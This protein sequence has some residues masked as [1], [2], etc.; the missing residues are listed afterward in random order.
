MYLVS[1]DAFPITAEEIREAIG[2]IG[3]RHDATIEA[4]ISLVC[5]QFGGRLRRETWAINVDRDFRGRVRRIGRCVAYG[6]GISS[7][8]RSRTFRD[9]TFVANRRDIAKAGRASCGGACGRTTSA[10]RS[11]ASGRS[12]GSF[13][14]QSRDP[15]SGARGRRGSLCRL[16]FVDGLA[17]ARRRG[18]RHRHPGV[19]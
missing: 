6:P 2:L 4:G 9:C 3:V 1:A 8:P 7:D 13:I 5:I 16:S 12:A 14:A 10:T 15:R 11:F 17:C 18:R 19:V